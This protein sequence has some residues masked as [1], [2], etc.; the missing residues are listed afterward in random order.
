MGLFVKMLIVAP[1]FVSQSQIN[2]LRKSW[3]KED[4][5]HSMEISNVHKQTHEHRHTH[6]HT[7]GVQSGCCLCEKR[8]LKRLE[9]VSVA[10]AS[11]LT[12]SEACPYWQQ[13]QGH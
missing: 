13:L 10:R 6:T 5:A 2:C 9:C 12:W 7:D 11:C 3:H 1:V 8:K 4:R